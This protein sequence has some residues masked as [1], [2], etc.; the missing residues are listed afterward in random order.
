M[1]WFQRVKSGLSKTASV[2]AGGVTIA[3]ARR[4]IDDAMLEELEELLIVSDLGAGVSAK[5]IG[6]LKRKKFSKD[7]DEAEI[8]ASISESILHIL[9]PKASSLVFDKKPHVLMLCG[10][11][12]NGKTT[13]AGKIAHKLTLS[14][15]KVMM[16]ACDTFRAAAYEQLK[17]WAERSGAELVYGEQNSD[18]ASVA[19]K[20][21]ER[22]QKEGYDVLIVDTAGRLHNKK[23]LMDELGKIIRVMQKLDADAPH[24]CVLVLDA[25]TG[26]NAISQIEIFSETTKLNGLI[27]TKLDGTAKGGILVSIAQRFNVP[28]LLIGVGEGIEDLDDFNPKDFAKALLGISVA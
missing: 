1:S 28:I 6:D 26:Q 19:Y 22:A 11:N 20:A 27:I 4:K 7:A 14:G 10:V 8:K 13:T 18:P 5:I 9:E 16:A 2:I 3:G 17:V 15:K 24:D 21:L 23:H 12:G 25:T